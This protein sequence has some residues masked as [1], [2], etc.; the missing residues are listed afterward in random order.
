MHP[1]SFHFILGIWNGCLWLGV[2]D[3]TEF[4]I[5]LSIYLSSCI[6]TPTVLFLWLCPVSLWAYL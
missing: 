4:R 6:A 5:R 2:T 1:L 3:Q